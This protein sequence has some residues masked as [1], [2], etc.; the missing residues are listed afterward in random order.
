MEDL[1]LSR[2][3][4]FIM[5]MELLKSF[6]ESN[7]I[8]IYKESLWQHFRKESKIVGDEI[9]AIRINRNRILKTKILSIY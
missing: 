2:W 4:A 9:V 7:M 5:H 3:I 8:C 6:K 1:A